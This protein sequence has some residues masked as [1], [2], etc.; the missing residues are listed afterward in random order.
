[1]TAEERHKNMLSL[2]S[3]LLLVTLLLRRFD[4]ILNLEYI[5]VIAV[6]CFIVR[7]KVKTDGFSGLMNQVHFIT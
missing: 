5:A 7:V 2:E 6:D 3:L 4:K 1:M